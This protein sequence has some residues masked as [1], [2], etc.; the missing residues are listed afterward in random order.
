MKRYLYLI[1]FVG[2]WACSNP[3][4]V[5]ENIDAEDLS[6]EQVDSILTHFKFQYETPEV[7][8]SSNQIMIPISTELIERRKMYSKDGYYYDD[9]PRYWNIMFYNRSTG[10]RRLLTEEKMSISAIYVK[11]KEYHKDVMTMKDKILYLISDHDYN[12]DGRLNVNDPSYL[13][14]SETNGAHLKRVSPINENLLHHQVIPESNQIILKTKRDTNQDSIFNQSDETIWY[15]SEMDMGE[16]KLNEIIDSQGRD[17]I[18][19]L[20][21][22]QWLKKK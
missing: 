6:V 1:C 9:F 18:E 10:E 2:L 5:L 7:L 13:F 16:W 19:K 4:P 3:Q 12:K 8:D 14:V 17:Q 15:L 22:E 20:Y 21:F 11:N